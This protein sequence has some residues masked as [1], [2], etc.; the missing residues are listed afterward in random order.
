MEIKGSAVKSIPEFVKNNY[1]DKYN[2]WLDSLP[3]GAKKIFGEP[4]LPSNW[5]PLL[6]GIIYPVESIG[7]LFF[8]S[9]TAKAA[10]ETGR[11]SADIAL[12]GIYKFF[13]MAATPSFIIG[14]ASKIFSTYYRPSEIKVVSN[15]EK[16]VKLHITSFG[17]PDKLIE[18]RI[19]GWMERG[20]EI[21]GC[22]N[23]KV[24][25][26]KSLANGDEVTEYLLHWD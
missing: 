14:R 21:S 5:Y 26:P 25:I 19:G 23:V 2:Q 16:S 6:E 9:D 8:G 18:D 10:W 11:Y 7:D 22:K 1:P 13:V 12:T 20:L 17:V 4:V 15:G 24:E 3:D